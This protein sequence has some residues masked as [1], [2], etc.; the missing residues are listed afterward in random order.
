[1]KIVFE[2][3]GR[4]S[5][6]VLMVLSTGARGSEP[7]VQAPAPHPLVAAAETLYQ[8]KMPQA[9]DELVKLAS[10]APGLTD[11][12]FIR[13]QFV[14][15]MRGLDENNELAARRS[16]S[17]V[18]QIDRSA[19][20][21]PF[22]PPPLLRMLK[23]ARSQISGRS[24]RD[25]VSRLV[26]ANK[27][28]GAREPASRALL[29]AVDALYVALELEGADVVL[30]L[31]RSTTPLAAADRAQLALRQGIL[32]MES[33]EDGAARAAFRDALEADQSIR[34]P[35]Y[36]SPQALRTFEEVRLSVPTLAAVPNRQPTRAPQPVAMTLTAAPLARPP[37]E[38]ASRQWGLIVGGT[39]LAI[40]GG[41][42]VAGA[43]AFSLHQQER[44]ASVA[45]DWDA[46]SKSRDSLR[47]VVSVA[48]GLYGAGAVAVG[49]GAFLFL[50]APRG[51]S[52][53]AST[54]QGQTSLVV[55]GNF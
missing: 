51:V 6:L 27:T 4:T 8:R 50:T 12:D 38:N 15:A 1:M 33:F 29:K 21:P 20:P 45:G 32:K 54:G 5:L 47:T 2:S 22:A 16:L 24:S 43:I 13:L 52:V 34:L 48:D 55:G 18:L 46:F 35:D 31:A 53:G 28:A 30:V 26:D 44:R 42:A 41:G 49:V 25:K 19:E 17:Q 11:D 3:I 37:P 23:E 7:T 39:G 10:M 14:V 40:L 36:V 9:C